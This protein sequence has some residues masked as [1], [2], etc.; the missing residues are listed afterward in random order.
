[1]S[2]RKLT[3]QQA[4]EI[5]ARHADGSGESAYALAPAFGVSLV[6]VHCLR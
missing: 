6:V 4:A 2:R 1:M 5:R 3:D